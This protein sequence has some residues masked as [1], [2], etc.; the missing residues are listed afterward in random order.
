MEEAV[1]KKVE[2]ASFFV[3]WIYPVVARISMHLWLPLHFPH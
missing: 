3:H 1:S 2:A